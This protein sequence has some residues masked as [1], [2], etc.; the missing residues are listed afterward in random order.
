M[1]GAYKHPKRVNWLKIETERKW[2]HKRLPSITVLRRPDRLD[3]LPSWSRDKPPYAR[4][5]AYYW[6]PKQW[7][8]NTRPRWLLKFELSRNFD[9]WSG[10]LIM[11]GR[12]W[13]QGPN[14]KSA[15]THRYRPFQRQSFINKPTIMQMLLAHF[16][17]RMLQNIMAFGTVDS[18]DMDLN[19]VGR[20]ISEPQEAMPAA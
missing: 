7:M 19:R 16:A 5:L 15:G 12:V 20:I 14:W 18:R 3:Y 8:I 9:R 11:F 4:I 2:W 1:R 6:N 10:R 17:I 13:W